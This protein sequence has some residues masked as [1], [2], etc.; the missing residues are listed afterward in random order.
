[1]T[2]NKIFTNDGCVGCNLCL[3]KC[4]C[5]EANIVEK[6]GD[7]I[8]IV[9]DEDKCIVCGECL[10]SCIHNA[11][12][13]NDDTERFISDLKT[14][15]KIPVIAAPALRPNV[16]EWPNLLGYLKSIG[17]SSTYDVSYGADICTWAHLRYI[18]KNNA[19]GI[20]TQPCPAIVNYI[21]HYTPQLL[22]CLSPIHSPAMCAAIYMKNY[23]N[24]PGP[25][26]F[27]SPCV[28]KH[29]EFSDPNTGGLVGY[30]VTYKKLVEYL[31]A[32]GISWRSSSPVGYE[33]EA[34]GLGSIY[35]S[36]GGL[37]ANV[38]Q[39]VKGNWIFQIEGQPHSSHFLDTYA[40]RKGTKPFIVDIL[41]CQRGCNA[42]TGSICTEEH[43][44]EISEAMYKVI[45]DTKRNKSRKGLPPGPN[46]AR[47][48]KD[49]KL[50]DFIR[51]YTD[52]KVR[53]IN[54]G[55]N[56]TEQA[57]MALHKTSPE[58]RVYDCRNCGYVTCEKMA[59]A[60]AKGINVVDNCVDY[61]RSTLREQ[62]EIVEQMRKK[63][64]IRAIEVKEAIKV[65]SDAILNANKK[66]QD[67]IQKVDEIHDEIE[68]LVKAADQ[69]NIIVPGL[70]ELSKRYSVTGKS[71]IDISF[72]TN[73]L[74]LNAAVEAARAGEHGK[75][76]AVV[77]EEV[78]S[79]A[80]KSSG[81]ANES[82]SNNE[83]MGPLTQELAELK[84][85]IN[86]RTGEITVNSESILAAMNTLE[87]L[88]QEV[89]KRAEELTTG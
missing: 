43:E 68:A 37:K 53:T 8:T 21:E 20:I 86:K 26:A 87:D 17:V 73:I 30:N 67:T 56:E 69:L 66:T 27:L 11:R 77:A 25:Y 64:E 70:E 83:K 38:E 47:F 10:R 49:L 5:D 13:Y 58:S 14:G 57:F 28:A 88:L 51:R 15:R 3:T 44:Y 72:Q 63:E 19:S 60:I 55:R 31:D 33:N 50:D 80:A 81:S 61:Q 48:D 59:I 54:V 85:E 32:Y 36:P 29:D 16:P 62:N 74:A 2:S 42:G 6:T 78:R 24:I 71:I 52:K 84:G 46:F 23:K 39:Y 41:N 45:E 4:P 76:F 22:T 12:D 9:I 7:K 40:D 1:M 65:M 75:G 79:L 82:L 34:H 18:K 89:E 35:S